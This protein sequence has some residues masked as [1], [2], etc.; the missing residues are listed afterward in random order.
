MRAPLM[1]LV[2]RDTVRYW[3]VAPASVALA[4]YCVR[5]RT[6]SGDCERSRA[7]NPPLEV[8]SLITKTFMYFSFL[9]LMWMGAYT[10]DL[11]LG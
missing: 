4:S 2:T 9:L 5:R 3:D 11:K 10:K 6:I 7:D 8:E 1:L